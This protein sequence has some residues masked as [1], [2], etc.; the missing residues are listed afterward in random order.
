M[1]NRQSKSKATATTLPVPNTFASLYPEAV[2]EIPQQWQL[3]ATRATV[4]QFVTK[5][6]DAHAECA[7]QRQHAWTR[8]EALKAVA[9][10]AGL[11]EVEID[12]VINAAFDAKRE[13]ARTAEAANPR[14]MSDVARKAI[15]AA[16]A[17]FA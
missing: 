3:M 16:R 12:A 14:P 5:L 6:V 4:P 10:S 15:E 8:C 13:K 1:S 2:K 7:R 17:A 11:S 9:L